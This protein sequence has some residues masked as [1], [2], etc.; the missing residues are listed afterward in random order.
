MSA[1][2]EPSHTLDSTTLEQ[3]LLKLEEAVRAL[4]AG[5]L[6]LDEILARYEQGI[7]HYR[8]CHSRLKEAEMRIEAIR[9]DSEG[10]PVLEPFDHQS[11]I[12]SA[13][14]NLKIPAGEAL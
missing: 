11:S 8:R 10:R 14:R 4:E 12:E 7:R 5:G 2:S 9:I 13:V 3:D 6:P 1:S